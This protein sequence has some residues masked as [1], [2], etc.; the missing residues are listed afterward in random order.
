MQMGCRHHSGERARQP[1]SRHLPQGCQLVRTCRACSQPR[2]LCARTC[3]LATGR[4]PSCPPCGTQVPA[5]AAGGQPALGAG[6]RLH[7]LAVRHAGRGAARGCLLHWH[8]LWPAPGRLAQD[9]DRLTVKGAAGAAARPG[10]GAAAAERA[11]ALPVTPIDALL[12]VIISCN[13]N[14]IRICLQPGQPASI[15]I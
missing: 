7:G 11:A 3:M 6:P 1:V 10:A 14:G 15:A 4:S 5:V 12:E 2:L 13:A 8:S 9:Q